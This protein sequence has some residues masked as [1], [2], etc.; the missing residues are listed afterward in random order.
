MRLRIA[1]RSPSLDSEFKETQVFGV[2]E[3]AMEGA[4][5]EWTWLR[6]EKKK[7]AGHIAKDFSL[8]KTPS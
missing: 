7:E 5:D 8:A 4:S 6:E 1:C 3:V 2:L